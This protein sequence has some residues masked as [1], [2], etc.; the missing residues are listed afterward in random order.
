MKMLRPLVKRVRSR[1]MN[2]TLSRIRNSDILV[3]ITI[4]DKLDYDNS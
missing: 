3:K 4:D 2:M 1:Q